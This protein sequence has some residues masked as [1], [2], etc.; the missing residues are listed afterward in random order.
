MRNFA[1]RLITLESS[2]PSSSGRKPLTAFPVPEQ[3]RPMLSRLMGNTG[4]RTL[5]ARALT[6]AAMETPW[7]STVKVNAEGSLDGWEELHAQL[8]PAKFLEG[9]VVLLA[10]LLGLLEAFIGEDLT[11]RL[12]SDVWPKL[13][14]E[15]SNLDKGDKNEKTSKA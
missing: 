4:F 10:H 15:D 2:G 13:S 12:V 9:R 11:V 5:L 8:G 14:L 7:L 6:L 3:L 1:T